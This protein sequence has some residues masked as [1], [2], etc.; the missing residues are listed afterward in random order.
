MTTN[1]FAPHIWGCDLGSPAAQVA[2]AAGWSRADILWEGLMEQV[3]EAWAR[4]DRSRAATLLRRAHLVA[5]FVFHRNDLRRAT[6]DANLGI[7]AKAAGRHG[8]A[9]AHFA[10]AAKQ[11]DANATASI[12]AM[13]IAP[14]ARSSLFHLR[15][16]A[17][18]R[19]TYH[20]NFRLRIGRIAD[21]VRGAIAALEEGT[22]P[23][24]RLYARWIGE[25]PTVYDDTRKTMAACLLII[26]SD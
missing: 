2:R 18:H 6:V 19:N 21:E 9:K 8:R 25:R 26:D 17:L 12:G 4:G 24:C 10:K 23:E 11:W 1:M 5:R 20:D 15:M 16:E 14:R 22:K 7:L 13:Q 3:N